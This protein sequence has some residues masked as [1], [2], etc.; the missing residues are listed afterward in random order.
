M[1]SYPFS[2]LQL[3]EQLTQYVDNR[4]RNASYIG[5]QDGNRLSHSCKHC[6]VII[7]HMH[8]SPTVLEV[9]RLIDRN[10]GRFESIM[11]R[12]GSKFYMRP[13]HLAMISLLDRVSKYLKTQETRTLY[14]HA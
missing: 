8:D 10:R 14:A 11:P 1:K 6:Q 5:G 9:Y 2:R 4:L 3:I 7:G 12:E 13:A